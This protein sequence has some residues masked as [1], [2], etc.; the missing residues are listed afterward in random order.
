MYIC[1]L[2][3]PNIW[4]FLGG[5][6]R[7][8]LNFFTQKV[9]SALFNIILPCIWNFVAC[10]YMQCI[11]NA[12]LA[13]ISII[14]LPRPIAER[15]CFLSSNKDSNVLIFPWSLK[16]LFIYP[17][18][19]E[20]LS[21][22]KQNNLN[23]FL[24]PSNLSQYQNTPSI[25]NVRSTMSLHDLWILGKYFPTFRAALKIKYTDCIEFQFHSLKMIHCFKITI[26]K[27]HKYMLLHVYLLSAVI[28]NLNVSTDIS[29]RF[30]LLIFNSLFGTLHFIID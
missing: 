7:F 28:E 9:H 12:Y 17:G 25:C 26:L 20:L 2:R 22:I 5:Q 1:N 21:V 29:N 11:R 14:P 19:M 4:T 23:F 18:L 8:L 3:I 27:F 13:T 15:L 16:A 30:Y 24:F 10:D 6:K